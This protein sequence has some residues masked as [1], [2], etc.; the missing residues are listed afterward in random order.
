MLLDNLLKMR[1]RCMQA[2][3]P[4]VLEPDFNFFWWKSIR[5]MLHCKFLRVMCGSLV[6][7]GK[8][9]RHAHFHFL[10]LT[11]AD[12]SSMSEIEK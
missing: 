3:G 4:L 8:T 7:F 1:K 5:M 12:A 6:S 2:R 10:A 9:A 11:H